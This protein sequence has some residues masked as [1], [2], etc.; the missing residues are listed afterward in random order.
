MSTLL[1]LSLIYLS[2]ASDYTKDLPII[3]KDHKRW[4]KTLNLLTLLISFDQIIS[5]LHSSIFKLTRDESQLCTSDAH[6]SGSI[7]YVASVGIWTFLLFDHAFQYFPKEKCR[8]K[9]G[10]ITTLGL[11]WLYFSIYIFADAP[12]PWDCFDKS[13]KKEGLQL[14]IALLVLS[15]ILILLFVSMYV[16]LICTPSFYM[17][18]K[19]KNEGKSD[20]E[21]FMNHLP[22]WEPF[23]VKNVGS[24]SFVSDYEDLTT[25]YYKV[26]MNTGEDISLCRITV[27]CIK[28]R[29]CQMLKGSCQMLKG[30]CQMLKGFCQMLWNKMCCTT[31]PND[32][33]EKSED[34]DAKCKC[35]KKFSECCKKCREC[36]K[37]FSEC[38]K[39]CRECCR[40]C[41]ECCKKCRECFKNFRQRCRSPSGGYI[42]LIKKVP[43]KLMS[44][45]VKDEAEVQ[46]ECQVLNPMTR[47]VST[48]PGTIIFVPNKYL[49]VMRNRKQPTGVETAA[50]VP[51]ESSSLLGSA[52]LMHSGIHI[53]NGNGDRTDS[54]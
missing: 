15:L 8:S 52:E 53:F 26:V 1:N 17:N 32:C 33:D 46:P 38:C 25:P 43:N 35:C 11:M 45:F 28:N 36:C 21:E 34:C 49:L 41:R 2:S 22:T 19:T 6:I 30:S 39:K 14:R 12:W 54:D 44:I 16:M 23:S 29:C 42:G 50:N 9:C 37:K 7:I 20:I 31:N 40:R 48:L 3:N 10:F 47:I 5:G 24:I 18:H 13:W 27:K 51:N 4:T